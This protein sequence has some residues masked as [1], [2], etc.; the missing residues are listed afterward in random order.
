MK[1]WWA[2]YRGDDEDRKMTEAARANALGYIGSSTRLFTELQKLGVEFT[3]DADTWVWYCHPKVYLWGEEERRKHPDKRHLLLTMYE[4]T[5]VPPEF[6]ESFGQVT[7]ILTPSKF[8]RDL[9]KPISHGKPIRLTGLGFDPDVFRYEPRTLKEGQPFKFL[10]CGAPNA[11]KGYPQ[12]LLAWKWCGWMRNPIFQLTM[13]T[14][15]EVNEEQVELKNVVFD[16]SFKSAQELGDLYRDHHCLLAPSHGEGWGLVPMEALATGMPIVSTKYSGVLDF[17]SESNCFFTP[18]KWETVYQTVK[19]DGQE[20]KIPFRAAA[21][22]I[23][24]LGRTMTEVIRQYPRALRK[25]AQGSRLVHSRF[26]W[27]LVAQRF[28]E[29][30]Q[31]LTQ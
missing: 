31:G 22:L 5:P 21:A 17:L 27:P 26:T 15:T 12:V 1:L 10:Y 7:A 20:R 19:E 24:D 30:I 14:T 25:A 6:G 28:V 11:R 4:S 29:T 2:R 18:Y 13:K 3:R 8:C 9:F 23:P 16:S